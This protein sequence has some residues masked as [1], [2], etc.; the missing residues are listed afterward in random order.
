MDLIKKLN[1]IFFG[2]IVISICFA[3]GVF[4]LSSNDNNKLSE[5][6]LAISNRNVLEYKKALSGNIKLGMIN[7]VDITEQDVEVEEP[8]ESVEKKKEGK[9]S[10]KDVE[11]DETNSITFIGG[12]LESSDDQSKEI[13]S[14]LIEVANK[15]PGVAIFTGNLIKFE[16]HEDNAVDRIL[17]I[18]KTLSNSFGDKFN[19]SFGESDI[20]CGD[21][22]VNGWGEVLFGEKIKTRDLLFAHSFKYQGKRILLLE[23]EFFSDESSVKL[24]W[25]EKELKQSDGVDTI[26]V[27]HDSVPDFGDN[28]FDA[29]E[30]DQVEAQKLFEQYKVK[31]V[32]SGDK[33]EFFYGEK[34]GVIYASSIDFKKG[35]MDKEADLLFLKLKFTEKE[36]S[37]V[38]YNK[39]QEV[40]DEFKIK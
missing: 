40:I 38:T 3:S 4:C 22:C 11:N 25:L 14:T 9:E 26:V 37:L 36:M 27:S 18:K 6:K 35:M 21:V 17:N 15:N 39:K 16:K 12:E 10:L 1:K 7:G 34:N 32:V 2:V 31:V 19:I 28:F 30:K 20:A 33:D 5:T 24:N 29:K 13:E 23:P 8:I